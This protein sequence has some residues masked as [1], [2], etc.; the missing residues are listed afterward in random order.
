[1]AVD[2]FLNLLLGDVVKVR[3]DGVWLG[4]SGT[5][6]CRQDTAF[7]IESIVSPDSKGFGNRGWDF[8]RWKA[9]IEGYSSISR[10]YNYADSP[11]KEPH[12]CVICSEWEGRSW[13]AIRMPR[14]RARQTEIGSK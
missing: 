2:F 14:L 12:R 3:H 10:I 4:K 6:L 13:Y 5:W 7:L 11:R 1:M 9:Q 8:V